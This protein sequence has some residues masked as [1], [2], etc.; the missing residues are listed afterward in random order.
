MGNLSSSAKQQSEPVRFLQGPE[1]PGV[2]ALFAY[3]N[4]KAR[5]RP[6]PDRADIVPSEIVRLLP[7]LII[8]EVLRGGE[9][10]RTRIFG[11]ALVELVGEERTGKCLSEFGH[12]TTVP[13]RP[14]IVQDRWFEITLRAYG[15][16]CPVFA[17]GTM[18]SS[19]RPY[20]VWHAV[21]CP[22]TAGGPAVEQMLGGLFVI[23]RR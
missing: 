8:S 4:E 9:D 2:A 11:T 3:W 14:E 5:G 21:S 19:D 16:A 17:T 13:T 15:G 12:H 23:D 20:L 1:H 18:A 22:L 10:F 6:M 7:N